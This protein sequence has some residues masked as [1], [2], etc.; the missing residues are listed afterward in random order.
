MSI[1]DP[2]AQVHNRPLIEAA[3]AASALVA[4]AGGPVGFAERHKVDEIL[5]SMLAVTA[6]SYHAALVHFEAFADEIFRRAPE[7]HAKALRAIAAVADSAEESR[8]ILRI[9]CAVARDES[10]YSPACVARISEIAR[11]LG[12]TMPKLQNGDSS[13]KRVVSERAYCITVGNQ[14]GGTGK[15]TTAMHLAVGLARR[16]HRV[17]GVDLDGEQGTFSHYLANRQA[18]AAKSGTVVPMP[19]SRCVETSEAPEREAAEAADRAL[20]NETFER[21]ADFDYLI[22]DTPGNQGRLSRLAHINAD[23]LI[24][25]MNDSFLDVDVLAEIDLDERRVVAPS[26]YAQMVMTQNEQRLSRG[27]QPIDWVVMRNR[28][29]QLQTRNSGDMTRLLERLSERMGFRLLPGLS[30]RMI[31]RELFYKG[32][33]LLDL[34][35]Q[36]EEARV[37]PSRWNARQEISRLVDAAAACR[38][39]NQTSAM[40]VFSADLDPGAATLGDEPPEAS[41]LDPEEAFLMLKEAMR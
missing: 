28:Q 22:L 5:E 7:G 16:G 6:F 34:P 20:L 10:R 21:F 17:A 35:E 18:Y 39:T 31:F 24:T 37:N 8:V 40:A 12:Q 41:D 19:V 11:I 1:L 38:E 29:A 13:P 15:S 9:A 4:T 33:T 36:P 2:S 26:A 3:M 27:W 14:K 32:L 30:E 23:L 25:P